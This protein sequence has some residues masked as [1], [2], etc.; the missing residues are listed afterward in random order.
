MA[1]FNILSFSLFTLVA[2]YFSNQHVNRLVNMAFD[3][4]DVSFDILPIKPKLNGYFLPRGYR[5]E[6]LPRVVIC[7]F[8]NIDLVIIT[9]VYNA[10]GG[11]GGAEEH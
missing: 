7:S 1:W 4:I 10:G 3:T 9:K 6:C 5:Y 8:Q 11:G 2:Y